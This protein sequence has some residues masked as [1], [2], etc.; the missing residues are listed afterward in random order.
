MAQ[1]VDSWDSRAKML[2]E[3]EAVVAEADATL[4]LRYL[5]RRC[6]E[7][8]APCLGLEIS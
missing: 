1:Y 8:L 4:A 5:Q 6:A 3:S 7:D 2:T